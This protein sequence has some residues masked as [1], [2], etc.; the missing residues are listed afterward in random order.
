MWI[1]HSDGGGSVGDEAGLILCSVSPQKAVVRGLHFILASL[2]S[3]SCL[4]LEN[5]LE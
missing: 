1:V 4:Y 2:E 3:H 5:D